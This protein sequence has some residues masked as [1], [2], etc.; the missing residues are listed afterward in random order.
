MNRKLKV[1]MP[2]TLND[3]KPQD[4]FV[5]AQTSF[6]QKER[7]PKP[8]L[9][10]WPF[11]L[12][13]LDC[14]TT[15]TAAQE[16]LFGGYKKGELSDGE[17]RWTEEGL[18]YADGLVERDLQALKNYINDPRNYP[19]KVRVSPPQMRLKLLSCA[20][21]IERVVW[22][23]IREGGMVV[24]FNTPFDLSRLA[25]HV[26]PA[27]NGGWSL[28]M[29]QR[30]SHKTGQLEI[31]PERPRIVIVSRDSKTAFIGLRCIRK[32]RRAEW[33]EEGRFLD[34]RTLGWALRNKAYSL[35]SA[36]EAFGVKGK[37]DHTPTGR[38][39]DEEI[40]YCREDVRA[41]ADLLNAMKNEFDRHPI[42]L[43]PD[44]AYS[45]ASIAKAYPKAMQIKLP[46]DK[47][48]LSDEE[49][50][51]PMAGYYGGRAEDRIRRVPVP[52][53]YTDFTSQYPTVNALLGNWNVLTAES[54]A[55]EDC[56]EEIQRLVTEVELEDTFNP[57]FWMKLSFFALVEPDHDLFPVRAVYNERTQNIG[58]NYLTSAMPMWFAGPDVIRAALDGHH[59]RILRAVRLVAKGR[60]AG[61]K[62]TNLAG[63][64]AIDPGS[65]DFFI[66]VI[67]QKGHYRRTNKALANSLKV[68]GTS[69]SYGAFVEVSPVQTRKPQTVKVYAGEIVREVQSDVVEKP[70]DWYFPP[71]ASLITAGGRLL[72]GMLERCV[73]D[74]GG[75]YLLCDT[76]SLCIVSS[77]HGGLVPCPGGP[78]K[79]PDG[80]DAVKALSW[81]EVPDIA[82]KFK[83]LNPYNAQLVP[84]ILKIEDLNFVD[85]DPTKPQR[86][87]HGYAVSAKRYA[88]FT[89]E[90]RSIQILKASGHG[91]GYLYPP[92]DSFNEEADAPQWIVE[93]WN[94]LLRKELGLPCKEPKWLDLPAMMRMVMTSPNVMRSRR[95]EWLKPFNFFFLPILSELGGYP[96][97]C[98]R[99][100]FKFITPFKS[101]PALW[102]GLMGINLL[103]ENEYQVALGP[104]PKQE[105]V[106]PESLRIILRQYLRH[107]EWKSLAPD[108]SPCD[109][110]TRGLLKRACI[111]AGEII[112]VGKETDRHWEQGEEMSLVE[113]KM[114][115]Y[116]HS[117]KMVVADAALLAEMR[118]YPLREWMRR[119]GLS[120]HT[121]EAILDGKLVRQRTLAIVKHA[122]QFMQ[123]RFS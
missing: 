107:P 84:E 35:N 42:G 57:A 62:S 121:I 89:R 20:D 67:E 3:S 120:Q 95:P 99:T 21:F 7:D 44:K 34:L 96:A 8:D 75:T 78:Y 59:P 48:H 53:V 43:R 12:V 100:N 98:N 17:Y 81:K 56:T 71:V 97:G 39:T 15:L 16:L 76:D 111:I 26:S 46:K 50:G 6:R 104:D 5:R 1:P 61:L 114:L 52:V 11:K 4:V 54:A 102:D 60:Q 73:T 79:L 2:A 113:S 49:L 40:T 118:K 94:W 31:N 13:V 65:E 109:G 117:D 47:L 101:D 64:V 92:K 58:L 70:G 103:D 88:L 28:A 123:K 9:P 119:T 115:I 93:A 30:K 80:R 23:T 83:R 38:I 122:L 18:F 106:V 82:A 90:K 14:E 25:V 51:I 32:E 86:Q 74:R 105:K 85:C 41:T 116:R 27:D 87:V 63:M 110:E 19:L 55:F 29:S 108:G 72:L 68:I 33:P 22:K 112:P 69:G 91:L 36:C 77:E 66:H 37:L 10:V 45:P 24:G